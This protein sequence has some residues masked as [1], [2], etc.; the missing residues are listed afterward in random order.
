[1]VCHTRSYLLIP[2]EAVNNCLALKKSVRIMWPDHMRKTKRPYSNYRHQNLKKEL[3]CSEKKLWD[4]NE[5]WTLLTTT[6]HGNSLNAPS[7]KPI[8]YP[9]ILEFE[10]LQS[11]PQKVQVEIAAVVTSLKMMQMG[12][13]TFA[14][15]LLHVTSVSRK[16]KV[17]H[18]PNLKCW[19]PSRLHWSNLVTERLNTF[20][21]L[22]QITLSVELKRR[23]PSSFL[24]KKRD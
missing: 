14:L 17:I 22:M 21:T 20:M 16:W 12:T 24:Y 4:K 9:G 2:D 10:M 3:L 15:S 23:T 19:P 1:M 5:W 7:Q 18:S 13:S 11:S 8:H 6:A